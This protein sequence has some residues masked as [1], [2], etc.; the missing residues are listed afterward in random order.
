MDLSILIT[1]RNSDRYI[2]RCLDSIFN[3]EFDKEY[4][5]I[6]VDCNSDDLTLDILKD[7][8]EKFNPAINLSNEENQ[9]E[10]EI[11][12]KIKVISGNTTN[13]A[14]A[15]NK[16]LS[17]CK[18]SFIVKLDPC[19]MLDDKTLNEMF[20]F[21]SENSDYDVCLAHVNGKLIFKNVS[22]DPHDIDA[23]IKKFIQ[24]EMLYCLMYKNNLDIT[25]N[26]FYSDI[27]DYKFLLD[28]IH[29]NKKIRCIGKNRIRYVNRDHSS[30]NDRL[31]KVNRLSKNV[32][33]VNN[34]NKL[35]DK[36]ERRSNQHINHLNRR[37]QSSHIFNKS[38]NNQ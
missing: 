22:H 4:E 21:L 35:N 29:N 7:Y 18:G 11:D 1:T 28:A 17:K 32:R 6:I 24:P 12:K 20:N 5:V 3:Q 34:Q 14:K 26:E 19:Y 25:Y 15:A 37:N 10:N 16:G 8:E 38:K 9:I 2:N 23:V 31:L 36:N 33:K 27:E 13:L 30:L